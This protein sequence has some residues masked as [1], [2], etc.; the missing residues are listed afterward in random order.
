M[1]K[2]GEKHRPQSPPMW[3]T[4]RI[5][6]LLWDHPHWSGEHVLKDILSITH[7]GTLKCRTI[8]MGE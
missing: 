3:G 5:P 1:K 4:L 6:N 2:A 7:F 8:S